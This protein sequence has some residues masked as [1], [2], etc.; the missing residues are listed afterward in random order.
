MR[1][2]SFRS[3]GPSLNSHGREAVEIETERSSA[4]G[5]TLINQECRPRRTSTS[6][7]VFVH[8]LTAAATEYRTFGAVQENANRW[9]SLR[10]DHRLLSRNPSGC[11]RILENQFG[12]IR[13][14][15]L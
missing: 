13:I 11:S 9:S 1:C 10:S 12:E 6:F 3:E 4:E 5:A 8:G 7:R 15:A 2:Q 14:P